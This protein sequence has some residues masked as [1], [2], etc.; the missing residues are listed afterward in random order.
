[1]HT[2]YTWAW[3]STPHLIYIFNSRPNQKLD[4]I[5]FESTVNH[6]HLVNKI[7]WKL[8]KQITCKGEL[9]MVRCKHQKRIKKRKKWFWREKK[10]GIEVPEYSA[11]KTRIGRSIMSHTRQ[12][13]DSKWI[14]S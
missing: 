11:A 1:M 2:H 13:L 3:F 10:G 4:S 12:M 5:L 9:I 7:S 14:E 6:N 8:E